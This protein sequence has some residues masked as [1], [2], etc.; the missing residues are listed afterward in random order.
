MEN[1]LNFNLKNISSTIKNLLWNGKV[2]QMFMLLHGTIDAN[3][4]PLF[5]RMY[6]EPFVEWK[7]FM[8]VRGS[9]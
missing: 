6:K 9:S 2:L 3:K 4:E 5:L 8:D 1:V 7:G